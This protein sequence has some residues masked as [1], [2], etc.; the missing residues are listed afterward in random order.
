MVNI[1]FIPY[2]GILNSFYTL[3]H[4]S[5]ET[6]VIIKGLTIFTSI[7]NIASSR[8]RLEKKTMFRA[9]LRDFLKYIL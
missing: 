8:W 4:I 6:L 2:V 3:I 1:L 7:R 5:I 9:S